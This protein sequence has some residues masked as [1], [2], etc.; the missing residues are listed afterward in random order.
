MDW[1]PLESSNLSACRYDPETQVLQIRFRSGRS[2][3]YKDVPQT[4]AEGLESAS[5]PGRYFNA[6]IK[7][8]YSES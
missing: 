3:D 4:V 5:S 2:Y 6:A 8:Q 1:R 7:G